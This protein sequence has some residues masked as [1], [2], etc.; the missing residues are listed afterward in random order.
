MEGDSRK[1][2]VHEPV[3]T[4]LQN[5]NDWRVAKSMIRSCLW[6]SYIYIVPLYYCWHQMVELSQIA[7]FLGLEDIQCIQWL[8]HFQSS[9]I[10]TVSNFGILARAASVAPAMF[11]EMML[12]VVSISG[13][14]FYIG[15]YSFHSYQ[16]WVQRM[17]VLISSVQKYSVLIKS[18][19]NTT[20]IAAPSSHAFPISITTISCV[21]RLL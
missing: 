7:L 21:L 16:F 14:P 3:L 20:P 8:R 12:L 4:V 10:T 17:G 1:C 19:S 9:N 5:N 2:A 13:I 18:N 11:A 15:S 6:L